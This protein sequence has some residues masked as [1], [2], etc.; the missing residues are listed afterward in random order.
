MWI[1]KHFKPFLTQWEQ[2]QFEHQQTNL[3]QVFS[4][5]RNLN[6]YSFS[7]TELDGVKSLH[8]KQVHYLY[9]DNGEYIA[10]GAMDGTISWFQ[11]IMFKGENCYLKTINKPFNWSLSSTGK[12]NLYIA[13]IE[14]YWI[15]KKNWTYL[16]KRYE[17]MFGKVDLSNTLVT[18]LYKFVKNPD[19]TYMR[20]LFSLPCEEKSKEKTIFISKEN[21]LNFTHWSSLNDDRVFASQPNNWG[22]V[23]EKNSLFFKLGLIG[24]GGY[25]YN[26]TGTPHNF[27]LKK[28]SF[29]SSLYYSLDEHLQK[30]ICDV[31]CV[32]GKPFIVL[33][34][35]K[36]K[37]KLNFFL[38]G[39]SITDNINAMFFWQQKNITYTN[40]F[41]YH[42]KTFDKVLAIR[43]FKIELPKNHFLD[44]LLTKTDILLHKMLFVWG[45]HKNLLKQD[46]YFLYTKLPSFSLWTYQKREILYLLT[47]QANNKTQEFTF[48]VSWFDKNGKRV[49]SFPLYFDSIEQNISL[50]QALLYSQNVCFF[51]IQ[52]QLYFGGENFGWYKVTK[53]GLQNITYIDLLWNQKDLNNETNRHL[54]FQYNC[55]LWDK[56]FLIKKNGLQEIVLNKIEELL[57]THQFSE[58]L[59]CGYLYKTSLDDEETKVSGIYN[60]SLNI[61]DIKHFKLSKGK[62]NS[63]QVDVT[64]R[65]YLWTTSS[66]FA[67]H[68]RYNKDWTYEL[69]DHYAE[70]LMVLDNGYKL[71]MMYQVHNQI[72]LKLSLKK[73][74]EIVKHLESWYGIVNLASKSSRGKITPNTH[75]GLLNKR[76]KI[77]LAWELPITNK[78]WE[79]QPLDF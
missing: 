30:N 38:D 74:P 52:N 58:F 67:K 13:E 28:W 61:L 15:T 6:I 48:Y 73:A 65:K 16:R 71:W 34:E 56:T 37:Q 3:E 21:N 57:P 60:K 54:T 44:S 75:L 41:L 36:G 26:L 5:G 66:W 43:T 27:L 7:R 78:Y 39:K 79:D 72:P 9:A 32:N 64:K 76:G 68:Q 49:Q 1:Q 45:K 77:Y 53:K 47:L 25:N 17:G 18:I 23:D 59:N 29:I 20:Y 24:S 50:K 11:P 14:I 4:F 51:Q 19:W 2:T 12:R 55:I 63:Y 35:D 42:Q 46:E 8:R 10:T 69:S 22:K 70:A 31:L 62:D 40:N 33:F